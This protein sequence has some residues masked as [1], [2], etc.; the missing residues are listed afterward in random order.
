MNDHRYPEWETSV[1]VEAAGQREKGQ[2]EW[3]GLEGRGAAPELRAE[4][5]AA[6]SG[7][8]SEQ[9]AWDVETPRSFDFIT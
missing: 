1:V 2:R 8:L 3:R 5:L 7:L 6:N 4:H 9:R